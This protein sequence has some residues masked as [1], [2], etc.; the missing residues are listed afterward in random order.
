M[1]NIDDIF[2]TCVPGVS[3]L[4]YVD[5]IFVFGTGETWDSMEEC[6]DSSLVYLKTWYKYWKL[7]VDLSKYSAINLCRRRKSLTSH[8]SIAGN[9]SNWVSTTSVLG[10]YF[11]HN[12]R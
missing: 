1:L 11:S 2:Q 9:Q 6:V 10:I 8:L 3:L 4:V 7:S 12:L 5:D